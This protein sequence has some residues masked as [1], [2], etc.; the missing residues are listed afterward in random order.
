VEN[1][2]ILPF[3]DIAVTESIIKENRDE[4]ALVIVEPALGV[5][6]TSSTKSEFWFV[7]YLTL[8]LVLWVKSV[9]C[10]CASTRSSAASSSAP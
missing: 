1:T 2:I 10:S 3:N 7:A 9:G 6:G 5:A 4:L 8:V